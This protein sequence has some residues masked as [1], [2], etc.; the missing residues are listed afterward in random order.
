MNTVQSQ[1]WGDC[2]SISRDLSRQKIPYNLEDE[3]TSFSCSTGTL[4]KVNIWVSNLLKLEVQN[5]ENFTSS[6][7]LAC[8]KSANPCTG[9][10][11]L[12][13]REN[14]PNTPLACT[15]HI[16]TPREK[17]KS[18]HHCRI[19]K[20]QG[21]CDRKIFVHVLKSMDNALLTR[22]RLPPTP[23]WKANLQ[24]FSKYGKELFSLAK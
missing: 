17:M 13:L 7:L 3:W 1:I 22:F 19:G 24:A 14:D 23:I 2:E 4:K 9:V 21:N 18:A 10:W 8:R 5:I 20:F 15:L 12:Q 16:E 6:Y 11:T